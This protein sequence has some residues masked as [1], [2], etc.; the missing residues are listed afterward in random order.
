MGGSAPKADP[1]IGIAAMKSA[2]TGQSMLSWMQE[3]AKTT[4]A[5]AAEDRG[6]YQ[7]TFVPLQDKFISEAQDYA[8]PERRAAAAD[9]AAGD[10]TLAAAQQRGQMARQMGA[11]GV[12]PNS[13]RFMSAVGRQGTDTALA[14][15]GARNLARRTVDDQGRQLRASAV[16]MGSGLAVNPGTSMGLSNQS[17]QA[18]FS[19]AMQ[20]Y[21][22]QATILNQ[23][24]QN[25]MQQYQASQGALG[26]LFGGLG[27]IAGMAF[28]S[29]K[30]I[31]TDKK[32]APGA[33]KAV[34]AMPVEKWTYK[35]GEG[36]GGTHIGP[37]AEDFAKQTG[38]GDGKSIDV[39]SAMGVT[40]GAVKE[41]S[42]KVD[43]L[44]AKRPAMGL[45][46]RRAA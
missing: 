40:M 37:Y 43:K 29:S 8:S 15:A 32:P 35:K 42:A 31:K 13:G 25:R 16:N 7:K 21:G 20:G 38:M 34:E 10:V 45:P 19:G 41:L 2:E 6:R 33:L 18:G 1:N 30:E 36:D 9:A 27:S 11:M 5:W 44:A 24:Y 12:N 22:Q 26:G 46:E 39:I 14:T 4:N 17:G 28:A 23:D 3:Q